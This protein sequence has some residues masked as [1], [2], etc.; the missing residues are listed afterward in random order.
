MKQIF[1]SLLICCL[2]SCAGV[3]K[4]KIG[5]IYYR[6]AGHEFFQLFENGLGKYSTISDVGEQIL[7]EYNVLY[8]FSNDSTIIFTIIYEPEYENATVNFIYNKTKGYWK[9]PDMVGVYSEV[10]G[11]KLTN[12][13]IIKNNK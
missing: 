9:S 2:V 6:Q 8:N 13:K 5:A 4:I 10:K 3:H 1:I 12:G 7:N 11:I